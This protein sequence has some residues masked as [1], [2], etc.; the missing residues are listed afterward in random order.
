[1][2]MKLLK[3]ILM[4]IIA[5]GLIVGN[6]NAQTQKKS[7]VISMPGPSVGVAWG[8]SYGVDG[9]PEIF[10]PQLAK[11]NVHLTKLY[12]FWQQIEPSKRQYNWGAVDTFLMQLA[13]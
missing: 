2:T 3:L 13:P 5:M 8:F 6:S 7:A 9:P 12:L 11:M 1:M 4:L 10:L